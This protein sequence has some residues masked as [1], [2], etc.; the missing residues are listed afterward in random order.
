MVGNGFESRTGY[1]SAESPNPA[2]RE[3]FQRFYRVLN[4]AR[5]TRHSTRQHEA[6][7]AITP[8]W[9]LAAGIAILTAI[10]IHTLTDTAQAK[11]AWRATTATWYGPGFYGN[12]FACGG[13][14]RERYSRGVA[15]MTLPCG[16]RLTVC[17]PSTRQCTNVRVIDRGAFNPAN[18]DLT[19]RTARDLLGCRACRPYTQRVVY[20]AGWHA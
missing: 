19:A 18:L 7:Y 2:P 5:S 17:N 8:S 13:T 16:A 12:T 9:L 6:Q 15:H 11:P 14:Y 10:L 3:R 20:R 1:L 4:L